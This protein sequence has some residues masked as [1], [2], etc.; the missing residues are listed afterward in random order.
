MKVSWGA[1]WRKSQGLLTKSLKSV[2][3]RTVVTQGQSQGYVLISGGRRTCLPKNFT[4]VNRNTQPMFGWPVEKS[5]N[6]EFCFHDHKH[7]DSIP[8]SLL[9][10][11]LAYQLKKGECY[12][13]GPIR[14]SSM[15]KMFASVTEPHDTTL[16]TEVT[17]HRLYLDIASRCSH[18]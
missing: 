9:G 1:Q 18:I 17:L 7:K 5:G 4:K 13:G 14:Y 2:V 6:K 12:Q 8:A 10:N 15:R 11:R 16:M 3:S